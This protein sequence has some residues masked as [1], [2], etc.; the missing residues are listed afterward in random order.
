M[1]KTDD[2]EIK[3]RNSLQ[4][5]KRLQPNEDQMEFSSIFTVA[6]L[7]ANGS[8]R[9]EWFIFKNCWSIVSYEIRTVDQRHCQN[10]VDGEHFV[11]ATPSEVLTILHC[12]LPAAERGNIHS[13]ST[14][15]PLRL[16]TYCR[17]TMF[18]V[19]GSHLDSDESHAYNQSCTVKQSI[20]NTEV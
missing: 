16:H 4:K 14:S 18:V 1:D 8:L 13:C 9:W 17:L 10:Y 19:E 12:R 6:I 11:S 5:L 20:Q 3:Y 15:S 2:K 7:R